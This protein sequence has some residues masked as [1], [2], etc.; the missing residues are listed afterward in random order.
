MMPTV[1]LLAP[2]TTKLVWRRLS[3]SSVETRCL[4]SSVAE[5]GCQRRQIWYHDIARVSVY[6]VPI[7][8]GN[9][10]LK[11]VYHRL[12]IHSVTIFELITEPLTGFKSP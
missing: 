11:K 7:L 12:I 6:I 5:P 9:R 10:K 8:V 3:S 2:V 4:F 1:S